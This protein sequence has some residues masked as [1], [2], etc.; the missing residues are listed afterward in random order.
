M[1]S[2]GQSWENAYQNMAVK[3]HTHTPAHTHACMH[4]QAHM[5]TSFASSPAVHLGDVIF[6]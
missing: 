3:L 6:S 5:H 1:P 2:S 4:A